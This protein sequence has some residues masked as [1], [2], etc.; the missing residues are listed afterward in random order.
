MNTKKTFS[1][2]FSYSNQAELDGLGKKKLNGVLS[3]SEED[4]LEF[5]INERN[6]EFQSRLN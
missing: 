2:S 1:F 4:R 3:S 6:I 5:L